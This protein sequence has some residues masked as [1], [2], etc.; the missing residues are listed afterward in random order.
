VRVELNMWLG[1]ACACGFRSVSN[2]NKVAS[3]DAENKIHVI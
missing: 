2:K 3:D 1:H